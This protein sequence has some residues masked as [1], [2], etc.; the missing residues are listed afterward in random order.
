MSIFTDIA[1]QWGIAD[2][3]FATVESR[4]FADNNDPVYDEAIQQRQQND[5]AY[6]LFLFTRFEEA[7]NQAA[8]TVI[9]NRTLSNSWQDRRIWEAW[10]KVVFKEDGRSAHFMS[11][12][13][14]IV[15][16]TQH[17]YEIILKFYGG[18]NSIAHGGTYNVNFFIPD[19]ASEM[20]RICRLFQTQ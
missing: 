13:E 11:K 15:D 7:I 8:K 19:V 14:V 16:K 10:G 4:A 9:K 3:A 1:N 5:Q 18:R 2:G 12:V 20:E 17:D 6:F